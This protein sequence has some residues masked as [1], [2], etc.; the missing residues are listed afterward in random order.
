MVY[1]D[2]RWVARL[3]SMGC[4][5]EAEARQRFE[6]AMKRKREAAERA[7]ANAAKRTTLFDAAHRLATLL[8]YELREPSES[9]VVPSSGKVW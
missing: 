5:D 2:T 9:R 4:W 1:D 8:K 7:N 6:D 3:K